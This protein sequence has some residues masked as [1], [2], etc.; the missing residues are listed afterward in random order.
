MIRQPVELLK[1]FAARTVYGHHAP[2]MEPYW[3]PAPDV[4]W[5]VRHVPLSHYINWQSVDSAD[6]TFIGTIAMALGFS[7][8]Y[9]VMILPI[10]LFAMLHVVLWFVVRAPRAIKNMFHRIVWE[11]LYSIMPWYAT[12][13]YNNRE[14]AL[15]VYP[16]FWCEND[17]RPFDYYIHSEM[18]YVAQNGASAL[19]QFAREDRIMKDFAALG[20]LFCLARSTT[21]PSTSSPTRT[22]SL[23]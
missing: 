23:Q 9:P 5:I 8:D 21:T 2:P 10:Y 18:C 4:P 3:L 13:A 11:R 16:A 22:S 17:G 20:D 6:L 1:D 12:V 14:H 15:R 7:Y 19:R